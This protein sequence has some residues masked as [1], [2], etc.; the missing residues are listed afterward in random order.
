MFSGF[1]YQ[2]FRKDLEKWFTE[3]ADANY[4][5]YH[6]WTEASTVFISFGFYLILSGALRALHV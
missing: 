3:S 4:I 6:K 1:M 5:Q 2:E